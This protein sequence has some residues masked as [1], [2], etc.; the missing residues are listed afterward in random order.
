MFPRRPNN[1]NNTSRRPA[2]RGQR[3]A[4][5][6][7]SNRG[8]IQPG[9]LQVFPLRLR[10]VLP[11]ADQ[12]TLSGTAFSAGFGTEQSYRLNSLFDPDFTGTGH[13]PYGFDQITPWYY[14]YQVDMVEINLTFSD[15]Q[16]DG[17]YVG[18]FLKNFDDTNTL[19]G[20]SISSAL[21]RPNVFLKPLNN[22]GSQV[23]KF[24]KLVKI[25]QLM[26]LTPAQ[27]TNAWQ[28]TAASVTANPSFV[29]YLSFAVADA[30]AT[31]PALTCKI[32]VDLKFHC[33]FWERGNA[34][35][36]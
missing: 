13:Q 19:T 15:P 8:A 28:Q 30:N 25:H 6:R 34:A 33:T 29:G 24:R 16:G 18:V 21:E 27:Y 32:T 17:L 36:S 22:T 1:N 9:L 20:A 5:N 11:Y 3:P 26:G 10:T 31:S 35:P 4:A 12:F 7:S 2:R 14:K 23:V